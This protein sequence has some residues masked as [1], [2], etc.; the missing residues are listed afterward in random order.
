MHRRFGEQ[1]PGWARFGLS[2]RGRD[3]P[4]SGRLLLQVHIHGRGVSKETDA[5]LLLPLLR[6]LENEQVCSLGPAA[7]CAS[8]RPRACCARCLLR[9]PAASSACSRGRQG[10]TAAPAGA[11]SVRPGTAGHGQLGRAHGRGEQPAG[12]SP[13]R[14]SL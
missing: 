8:A 11:H 10:V 1:P 3:P 13:V 12:T 14:N 9:A 5:L 6:H 4:S 7:S 2:R